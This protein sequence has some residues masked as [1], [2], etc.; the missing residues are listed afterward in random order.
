MWGV[1][2]QKI[3]KITPGFQFIYLFFLHYVVPKDME[4]GA[5][6]REG[7]K[8]ENELSFESMEQGNIQV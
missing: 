6:R 4:P 5:I 3:S 8:G 1:G 7:V 2:E